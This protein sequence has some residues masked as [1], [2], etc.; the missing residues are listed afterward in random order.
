MA[1]DS[2]SNIDVRYVMQLIRLDLNEEEVAHFQTQLS[3]VLDVVQQLEKVDVSHVEPTAYAQKVFNVF[4]KDEVQP[5]LAP[6]Q[7][8]SNAPRQA[9]DLFVVTKVVE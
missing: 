7:A 8:L 6:K 3:K 1:D 9:N 4:R 2:H 5:S